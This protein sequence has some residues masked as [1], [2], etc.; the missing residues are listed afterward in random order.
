MKLNSSEAVARVLMLFGVVVV[1]FGAYLALSHNPDAF[2][3]LLIPFFLTIP[4]VLVVLL[5]FIPIENAGAKR[6]VRWISFLV[7]PLAAAALPWV[8]LIPRFNYTRDAVEGAAMLSGVAVI[9]SL[10][11]IAT[12]IIYA[13]F[14]HAEKDS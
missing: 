2:L 3:A 8:L 11:W 10:G 5:V 7:I 4:G 14:S 1:G 13:A 9:L 6:G 12:R